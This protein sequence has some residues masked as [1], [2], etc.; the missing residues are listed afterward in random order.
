V[1]ESP[2]EEAQVFS[3]PEV[4]DTTALIETV[5]EEFQ[6]ELQQQ[7]QARDEE[8]A[9]VRAEYQRR[10][11]E[12]QDELTKLKSERDAAAMPEP[13]AAPAATPPGAQENPGETTQAQTP[14]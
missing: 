8:L 1:L 10:I 12:L 2:A 5:R 9:K 3:S 6:R 13:P 7:L 4:E 11:D 14:Q